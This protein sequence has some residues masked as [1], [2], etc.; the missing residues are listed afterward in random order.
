[1]K[2][3]YTYTISIAH[4]NSPHLLMRM[5]KS[6]PE[7]DDIQ[8]VVVD[9]FSSLECREQLANLQHKNLEIYYQRLLFLG[10]R[11]IEGFLKGSYRINENFSCKSIFKAISMIGRKVRNN[12]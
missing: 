3:D 1:M 11:K 9:D 10:N 5:L 6:I 4:F 12:L 8:I 2:I 7:R